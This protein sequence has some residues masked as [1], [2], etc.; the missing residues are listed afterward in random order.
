MEDA[1]IFCEKV[2]KRL[3]TL[4]ETAQRIV[5]DQAY[6]YSQAEIAVKL[7][8]S[9]RTMSRK[10]QIVNAIVFAELTHALGMRVKL[11]PTPGAGR[12]RKRII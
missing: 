9:L 1:V 7:G 11:R 3:S 2:E 6:G 5:L 12:P 4:D 10:S 8:C